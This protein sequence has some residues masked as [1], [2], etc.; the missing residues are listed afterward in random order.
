MSLW[1]IVAVLASAV[2][3][4]GVAAGRKAARRAVD[5][6]KDAAIAEAGREARLRIRSEAKRVADE[7]LRRFVIGALVKAA[8][9]ALLALAH[10]LGWLDDRVFSWVFLGMIALFLARDAWITYPTFRVV[11]P[12]LRRHGFNARAALR[13][14]MAATVLAEAM[15]QVAATPP[16]EGWLERIAL[17]LDGRGRDAIGREIAETVARIAG[18]TSWAEVRPVARSAGLKLALGALAYSGFVA[19]LLALTS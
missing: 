12:E 15:R 6:R 10:L 2:A 14:H 18:E 7:I 9:V 17:A 13:E 4:G 16:P 19:V 5:L 8:L 3:A 11:W 1:R